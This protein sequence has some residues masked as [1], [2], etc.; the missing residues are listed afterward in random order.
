MPPLLGNIC[1]V[2]LVSFSD[3]PILLYVELFVLESDF[4]YYLI[5]HLGFLLLF[6]AQIFNELCLLMLLLCDSDLL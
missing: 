1:L 6:F 5:V 2:S 3:V 4:V